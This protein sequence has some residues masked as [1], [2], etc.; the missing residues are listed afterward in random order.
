M[1][2][3]ILLCAFMFATLL[4]KAQDMIQSYVINIENGKAYLDVATPKVKVGDVLSIREEAG[5]MVHPVTKKK[6]RKEGAILADL[7]VVEVYGEYSV[8]TVYPEEAVKKIKVGMIAE[9]PEL[10]QGYTGVL[11]DNSEIPD[12]VEDEEL[13]AVPTDADGIVRRYLQVTGLDKWMNRSS[14]PPFYKKEQLSYTTTKGK[15]GISAIYSAFDVSARK[16]FVRFDS[17]KDNIL[18]VYSKVIAVNGHEG[19]FRFKKSKTVKMKPKHLTDIWNNQSDIFGLQIY[20]TSKWERTLSGKKEI[21]GKV[22]S[23]VVFSLKLPQNEKQGIVRLTQYFDDNTGLISYAENNL[24]VQSEC[25]SYKQF[26]DLLLCTQT[27]DTYSEGKIREESTVLQEFCFDCPLDNSLF[28]K[29][30][31]KRAF[32]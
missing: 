13:Q 17:P 30:G 21:R 22:C 1:K 14:I 24:G 15:T 7:E 3:Y 20:D 25:L 18:L 32:K 8:A 10:P 26:G 28:T 31:V 9:M 23:G 29:E 2:K 11:Q 27:V 4:L 16:L 5:Y 12:N 19:W 6:I